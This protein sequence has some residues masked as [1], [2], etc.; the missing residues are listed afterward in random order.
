LGLI[1]T[2][3]PIGLLDLSRTL[4][5]TPNYTWTFKACPPPHQQTPPFSLN[6]A[7]AGLQVSIDGWVILQ[8]SILTPFKG[9]SSTMDLDSDY[10]SSICKDIKWSF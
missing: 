7:T 5:F 6:L 1:S 10:Y 4:A 8:W 3:A 2:F 9:F